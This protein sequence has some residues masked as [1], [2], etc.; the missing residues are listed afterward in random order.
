M[1]Y[2]HKC[3]IHLNQAPG[4]MLFSPALPS[5]AHTVLDL[6]EEYN[7]VQV[8]ALVLC[9]SLLREYATDRVLSIMKRQLS[10]RYGVDRVVV[11]HMA[12]TTGMVWTKL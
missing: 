6:F 9:S 7:P 8:S 2:L 4:D 5:F 1:S 12:L 10:T 3:L 11:M